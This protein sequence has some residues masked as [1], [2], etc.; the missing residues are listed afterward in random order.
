MAIKTLQLQ[1]V[2]NIKR[3]VLE[4]SDTL[5]LIIGDNGAGK[6]AL[7]EAIHTLGL[8]RSFR[9]THIN[10]VIQ[11]GETALL[12]TARLLHGE[13]GIQVG[14]EKGKEHTQVRI[15]GETVGQLSQLA[16]YLPIQTIHPL[17]HELLTDGPKQRRQYLDWGVFH[18]EHSYLQT[19]QQYQKAL[20]QRNAALRQQLTEKNV[21]L[22]D[23]ALLRF[24]DQMT[25]QRV[26]Y[27]QRLTP[28]VNQF[29]Q[30]LVGMRTNMSYQQGWNQEENLVEALERHFQRDREQG[31]TRSG[32]HRA[33]IRI[34]VEEKDAQQHISRGQ[35]K[36][37]VCAMRLAQAHVFAEDTGR[38]CVILVD[39]LPAELDPTHRQRLTEVLVETKAQLFI[40]LTE[41]ALLNS[42][43]WPERKM[44]HVEH[45]EIR[46]LL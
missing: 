14:V 2:R 10:E 38:R 44:F 24:A 7:L 22:W 30:A 21:R 20:R 32:P 45:G 36:L 26:L 1:H 28:V 34:T 29:T 6:S 31:H 39:D 16:E 41:A 5:N 17:S 23:M 40:T 27:L 11:R 4:P 25:Q 3:A 12:V 33:D 37:L 18:V 43:A 35:Q 46:E 9:T 8:G 19:W 15:G 42:S 13:R